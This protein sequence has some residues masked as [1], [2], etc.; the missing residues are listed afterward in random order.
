MITDKFDIKRYATL[1]TEEIHK[2]LLSRS[3][4]KQS[5]PLSALYGQAIKRLAGKASGQFISGTVEKIL[6]KASR[7][8]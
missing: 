1:G 2:E 7:V 8:S 6:K 5:A 3:L 4:P